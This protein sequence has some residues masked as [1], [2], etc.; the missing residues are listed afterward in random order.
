MPEIICQQGSPEWKAARAGV[1]TSSMFS[2]AQEKLKRASG[3]SKAGDP[4]K[5]AKDY[6][7]RLAVERISGAPLDDD[8][9]DT[10]AMRRGRE[11][12]PDARFLHEKERDIVVRQVGF[13][14]SDDGL[15]GSSVDGMIDEGSADQSRGSAEYKCFISPTSLQPILLNGDVSD[16]RDQ[17]QGSMMVTG[18]DWAEL[19]LYCPA[20]MPINRHLTIIREYRNEKYIAEL[21]AGLEEFYEL[22][23][24]YEYR[25]KNDK[26]Y[27]EWRAA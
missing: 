5:A 7:F 16:I 25:L 26:E 11:F 8:T 2:V 9:Y 6:A 1:V 10:Y 12:E 18:C 13:Y 22:V 20:L 17:L 23:Y 27:L 21:K 19:C 14:K 15:Y 24:L 3:S 4:S